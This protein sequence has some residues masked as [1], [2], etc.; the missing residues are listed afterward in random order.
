MKSRSWMILPVECAA[1][2][3]FFSKTVWDNALPP[4][5]KAWRY[6]QWRTLHHSELFT[7]SSRFTGAY[8]LVIL[9]EK[10]RSLAAQ[11]G[12]SPV[13]PPIGDFIAHDELVMEYAVRIQKDKLIE[14]WTS[15]QEMKRDGF[16]YSRDYQEGNQKIKYPDL[17]IKLNVPGDPTFIAVEFERSRKDN[18]RY[19]EFTNKYKRRPN[20]DSVI[21]LCKTQGI[22]DSIKRAQVRTSYPQKIRPMV[23]GLIDEVMKSPGQGKLEF[24]ERPLTLEKTVQTLREK[25]NSYSGRKAS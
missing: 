1:K 19:D 5:K 9:T 15:E 25:R 22:I 12:L 18:R 21:I 23:F 10:G 3:G 17:V 4:T 11:M 6:E 20:I 7:H 16:K 2:M 24:D 14:S 13:D 8:R